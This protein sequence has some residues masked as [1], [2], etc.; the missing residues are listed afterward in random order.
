[1]D[2]SDRI[3][4]QLD[5]MDGKLDEN[6]KLTQENCKQIGLIKQSLEGNGG[7]GLFKRMDDTEKWQKNH[8][9]E[10]ERKRELSRQQIMKRRAIE[11]S[12]MGLIIAAISVVLN[13]LL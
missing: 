11:V 2:N 9:E 5:K 8:T 1:M 10:L 12:I 13:L 4:Q 6:N 3:L 7:K